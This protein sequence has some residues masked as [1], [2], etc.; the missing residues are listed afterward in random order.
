MSGSEP[1][2]HRPRHW[3]LNCGE[4]RRGLLCRSQFLTFNPFRRESAPPRKST[5]PATWSENDDA[6][7]IT[8]EI[9]HQNQYLH[10]VIMMMYWLA[11]GGCR[12]QLSHHQSTLLFNLVLTTCSVQRLSIN[13]LIN[14]RSITLPIN[15]SNDST[16]PD[17][18]SAPSRISGAATWRALEDRRCD[19]DKVNCQGNDEL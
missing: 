17:N 19:N 8:N 10:F 14:P 13:Q 15:E 16:A 11:P 12:H 4:R 5:P 2:R 7:R 3:L 9:A 6:R 1:Q 18:F